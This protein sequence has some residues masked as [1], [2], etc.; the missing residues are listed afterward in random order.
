MAS[1]RKGAEPP[2][3]NARTRL[4]GVCHA[5]ARLDAGIKDQLASPT[6]V[7][8]PGERRLS[9]RDNKG[10]VEGVESGL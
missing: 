10:N 8:V 2:S 7:R 4:R 9:L 5:L 3:P 6:N 1:E